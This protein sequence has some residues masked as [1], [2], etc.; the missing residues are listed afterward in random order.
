VPEVAK[1]Y[2]RYISAA[3]RAVGKFAMYMVFGMMGILLFETVSRNIFNLPHIWVVE[4][5]QFTMA[6]YYLLGGG[7]SLIL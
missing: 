7:Y 2:V 5:A 3:S 6:A 4:V 1:A